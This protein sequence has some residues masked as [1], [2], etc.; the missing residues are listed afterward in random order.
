MFYPLVATG[1]FWN[2][3]PLLVVAVTLLGVELLLTRVWLAQWRSAAR[4]F[5]KQNF[6]GARLK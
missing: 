6:A 3:P 5:V 2:A 1:M 4:Q